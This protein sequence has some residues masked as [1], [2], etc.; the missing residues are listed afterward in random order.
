MA[1]TFDEILL[2]GL[3][4]GKIPARNKSARKWYRDKGK[5]L[6]IGRGKFVGENNERHR[7]V[8]QFEYGKMYYFFYAPK[9]AK[10]LPYYDTSPLIFPVGPAPKGFY[11]INFHYLDYRSRAK[12]MDALYSITTDKRYNEDTKMK[13]SYQ[14]L[15]STRKFRLFKPTFKHYLSGYVRSRM[16]EIHSVEWDIALFMPLANFKKASQ[17]TVWADSKKATKRKF[18]IF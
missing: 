8:K 16:V 4:A 13:L 15:K 7:T 18:G 1:T 6:T 12:L 5:D 14:V 10:T 17:S 9:H 2:K 11:G 3:R